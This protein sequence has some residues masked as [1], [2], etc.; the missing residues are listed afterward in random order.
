[1]NITPN[2]TSH[3]AD[4]MAFMSTCKDNQY[5][6]G[7]CDPNYGI[8]ASRPSKKPGKVKQKNGNVLQA[9]TNDY[10]H[11]DWDDRPPP[12]AYFDEVTRITQKQ[13]I[14]GVNYYP[15]ALPGGRLVWDKLNGGSD[16]YD[17]E[18]AYLSFTNRTE[19]VYYKWA[20]MMQGRKASSN[21][22]EAFAQ[23]GNKKLNEKRFHPTQKPVLLCKWML[24]KWVK[25]GES[26]FD[27]HS[28]SLSLAIA[29]YLHGCSF[30]GTELER[31]YWN[32]GINRTTDFIRKDQSL[33]L[34]A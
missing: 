28:G 32:D 13:I 15:T 4:C 6:W 19:M 7:I 11:K 14:W 17:C 1:M 9:P 22:R 2:I 29:C 20:G 18:L 23:Q 33:L 5:N 8:G 24:E 25:P 3:L 16:Q 21:I 31:D 26:V 30:E 10:E 27:S 12:K 34:C